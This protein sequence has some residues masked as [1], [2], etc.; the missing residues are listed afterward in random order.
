MQQLNIR[1][2]HLLQSYFL[3]ETQIR[4][5]F[6]LYILLYRRPFSISRKYRLV[7]SVACPKIAEKFEL[8]TNLPFR[9]FNK[10][11]DLKTFQLRL[12]LGYKLSN[13]HSVA[14]GYLYEN[15]KSVED[16]KTI[17]THENRVYQQYQFET[18]LKPVELTFRFRQEQRF[19]RDTGCYK[20]SQRT[21]ASVAARIPLAVN[22]DF[23]KG[24]YAALQNEIFLN[25]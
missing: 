18:E 24:W 6:L 2:Y 10:F 25:T 20:F 3:N 23:S 9:S 22:D 5:I 17:V 15:K 8:L 14:A 7:V 12:G 4:V 11:K 13:A 16:G 19:R 21:R 1:Q